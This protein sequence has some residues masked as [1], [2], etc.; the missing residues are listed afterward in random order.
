MILVEEGRYI[1]ILPQRAPRSQ[2]MICGKK[3]PADVQPLEVRSLGTLFLRIWILNT[4]YYIRSN[5]ENFVKNKECISPRSQGTQRKK[6]EIYSKRFN[7]SL[8]PL[9][10]LRDIYFIGCGSAALWPM[11]VRI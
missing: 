7:E 6:S 5:F 10:A 9:R 3:G 2:R 8:W 1:K 11:W 4:L